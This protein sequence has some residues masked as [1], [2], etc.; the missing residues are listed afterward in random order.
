MTVTSD[1][2]GVKASP[3]QGTAQTASSNRNST[4]KYHC[5]DSASNPG[6]GRDH[7]RQG[8]LDRRL[9]KRYVASALCPASQPN[10]RH[11]LKIHFDQNRRRGE[12]EN[13]R[14]LDDYQA[15]IKKGQENVKDLNLRFG[16]WYFVINDDVFHK[17][18]LSRDKVIKK[19]ELDGR[20]TGMRFAVS[21]DGKKLYFFGNATIEIYDSTTLES[22][23]VMYL[24]KDT[25][26]NLVTLP[27]QTASR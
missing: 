12:S 3:Y 4:A 24:D 7:A 27:Q 11:V 6:Q 18:R 5:V 22:K 21:S 25:T 20:P 26:T 1:T 15:L 17:I 13:Q 2:G 10:T 23:K 9:A 19:K 8:C 16:D 14:K